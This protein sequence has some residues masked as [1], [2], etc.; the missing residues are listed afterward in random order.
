MMELDNRP[1]FQAYRKAL[2]MAW[3]DGLITYDEAKILNS[4]REYLMISEEEHWALE[5]DIRAKGPDPGIKE[6]KTVLEQVWMD[7]L[8]TDIE[9]DLLKKLR[10]KYNINDQ[11]H[12]KLE[13]K[14]KSDLTITEEESE[15]FFPELLFTKEDYY[16]DWNPTYENSELF[17]INKGK[18]EWYS[19]KQVQEDGLKAM[20]YFDKA[21][22]INTKSYLAWNYKGCI[23]KKLNDLTKAIQCYDKVNELK[24]DFIASWY[25]KGMLLAQMSLNQ[26]DEAIKCFDEVLRINPNHPLALRDRE[27]FNNLAKVCTESQQNVET[28]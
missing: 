23:Y 24:N 8:L 2:E 19:S 28:R 1:E 6:Y 15:C 13:M 22:E 26:I 21:I 4:L 9:K 20:E 12:K 27:M 17:W 7:G 10:K 3:L 11:V 16:S 5:N 18:Q 25:N 14:V